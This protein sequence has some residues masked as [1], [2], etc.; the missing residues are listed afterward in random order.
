MKV[1]ITG[2]NGFIGSRVV[3]ALVSR[4]YPVRCLLRPNS[5]T[6]RIDGL[7]WERATGDVRDLPSI[8]N[9]IRGCD[10]VIHAASLSSWADLDSPELDSVVLG[11]TLNILE[12]IR[13][14]ATPPRL[15]YVGSAACLGGSSTPDRIPDE[16]APFELNPTLFRYAAL[17]RQASDSCLLAWKTAGIPAIVVH[18]A[19]TYGPGDDSHVTASTL[20]DF[21]KGAFTF[22]CPGGTS[23]VHVDD[24]AEAIVLALKKGTPG[25][26]YFLGGDN[27]SIREMAKTAHRVLGRDRP[28]LCIPTPF[29]RS[30]IAIMGILPGQWAKQNRTKYRY[31]NHFWF[32]SNTRARNELGATFR[33][34]EAT[35][36]DTYDWLATRGEDPF[37]AK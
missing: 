13:N 14:Q 37:Q 27:L 16:D 22:V 34:A 30:V 12:A 23:V 15:I 26:S 5:R 11:G 29:F 1:L 25:Q 8:L 35:F 36:R 6:H 7:Q 24:V 17:K 19:E 31:A 33:S 9:A 3:A 20:I 28:V 32:Y 2:G 18:P 21:A 4:G 10:A